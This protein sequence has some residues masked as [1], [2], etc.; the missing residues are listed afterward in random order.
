[1]G[2]KLVV[3]VCQRIFKRDSEKGVTKQSGMER[4][5]EKCVVG[6]AAEDGRKTGICDVGEAKV[7]R[8]CLDR[9]HQAED[10]HAQNVNCFDLLLWGKEFVEEPLLAAV[11]AAEA[12]ATLLAATGRRPTLNRLGMTK[13]RAPALRN[14]CSLATRFRAIW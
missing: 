3:L 9:A 6:I 2:D 14:I 5:P 1:M 4:I 13:W 12:K 8:V 7:G 10:I 11:L